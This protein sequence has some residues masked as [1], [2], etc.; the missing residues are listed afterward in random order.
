MTL[1]DF[2]HL[3][4]THPG[5]IIAFFLMIP[6]TA[7]LSNFMGKGEGHMSPWKFLYSTLIY[8][9]A[10]PGIFAI[11]LSIYLFLFERISIFDTDIYTQILPIISMIA[12]FL[13]IRKNVD[14]DN[15]PGFGKLSGL[16]MMISV[17]MIMMWLMEKTRIFVISI[18][19]FQ[20]VIFLF[21]GMLIVFRYGWSKMMKK[22]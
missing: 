20:N 21:I 14:L 22:S 17:I 11:T 15:V 4:A 2:F 16:I 19:P 3:L 18:V 9:V 13:I 1:R 6:L 10:V 12:T 5:Y 8:L 7:L